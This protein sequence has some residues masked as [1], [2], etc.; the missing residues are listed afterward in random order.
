MEVSKLVFLFNSIRQSIDMIAKTENRLAL[1]II[2]IDIILFSIFV[3]VRYYEKNQ[4]ERD[5]SL[6][7]I[8]VNSMNF[9]GIS[10]RLIKILIMIKNRDSLLQESDLIKNISLSYDLFL[11]LIGILSI[12]FSL[13]IDLYFNETCKF[14][15]FMALE[16]TCDCI[17]PYDRHN[18]EVLVTIILYQIIVGFLYNV[19]PEFVLGLVVSKKCIENIFY[20]LILIFHEIFEKIL[21]IDDF[22]LFIL[23][24]IG[25]GMILPYAFSVYFGN[26]TTIC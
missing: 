1:I 9:F 5:K 24:L 22:I 11:V 19:I 10:V 21:P 15:I 12:L 14:Y 13:I 2:S 23:Q 20:L 6:F 8:F 25:I 7:Y 17:F 3:L 18:G 16:S 4:K 26:N